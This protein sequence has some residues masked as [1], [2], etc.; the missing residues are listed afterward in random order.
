MAGKASWRSIPYSEG[1]NPVAAPPAVATDRS[2]RRRV[3]SL[4]VALLTACASQD[5]RPPV[6]VRDLAE[7]RV[8][9]EVVERARAALEEVNDPSRPVTR[10]PSRGGRGIV[11]EVSFGFGGEDAAPPPAA[12]GEREPV[13]AVFRDS[14]LQAIIEFVF[15]EVLEAPYTILPSFEDR[16]VDWFVSGRFSDAEFLAVVEVF[17]SAQGVTVSRRDGV[18]VV[19]GE[20]E[21]APPAGGDDGELGLT[22]AV[23]RLDYVNASEVVAIVRQFVSAPERVQVIGTTNALVV[24]AT[25][26]EV[27]RL[28]RFLM[29]TDVPFA[30][31]RTVLVYEPR[32]LQP[33][34][35]GRLVE[36]LPQTLSLRET[37]A[38]VT[39]ET[40]D[41][42][43]M[44]MISVA[45]AA[46]RDAV[47]DFLERV[48]TPS[49]S[50]TYVFYYALREQEAARARTVLARAAEEMF[51]PDRQPAI[52][53]VPEANSLMI[54]ATR[55]QFQALRS[56]LD[57]LDFTVPGL[58][59]DVTILEVQ[60]NETLQYGVEYFLS[61][62]SGDVLADLEIDLR[63]QDLID[64]SASLGVVINSDAFFLIDLLRQETDL[65]VL[66]RPRLLVRNR[67][68]ASIES[69]DD[70][71]VL[72]SEIA[73]EATVDANLQRRFERREVGLKLEITP[74]ISD[75]GR[76]NLD[77]QIEDSRRGPDD[78]SID[79]PQPTFNVR[80]VQ[81]NLSMENGQTVLIGGLFRR[82]DD[83]SGRAVPGLGDLP[84]AGNLFS[85][86]T[87]TSRN[88]ELVV[89]VTPYLLMDERTS[90]LMLNNALEGLDVPAR[91]PERM[92][93]SWNDERG[94]VSGPGS[95][96]P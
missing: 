4:L 68:T 37:S 26:G 58:V 85:S 64:P 41:T 83:N 48:D 55:N 74:R 18:Y 77:I 81:T 34:T 91:L 65:T 23:W 70:I 28:D 42:A 38:A 22:T 17:L 44:V 43:E 46:L 5:D 60:L 3:T 27:E 86:T 20:G 66:S 96:A 71:P 50:P 35:V 12:D 31:E 24:T 73:T 6:P 59:V 72:S 11:S 82:E 32:S 1:A 54:S 14:S 57:R 39:A 51:A 36:T 30:Q 15:E 9:P 87:R 67:R 92:G 47:V 40:I 13:D 93:T 61:L 89:I 8:D 79:P 2:M 88:T 25:R 16:P 49:G 52:T 63:P 19:A 94:A 80:R 10:A 29:T 56:I 33:A 53:E 62:T 7:P 75:T 90:E 21:A 76:I 78:T 84:V 69:I 95:A 45:N